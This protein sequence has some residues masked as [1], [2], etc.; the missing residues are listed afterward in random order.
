MLNASTTNCFRIQMDLSTSESSAQNPEK[1]GNVNMSQI[2]PNTVDF[3]TYCYI[4]PAVCT[5][6]IIGNITN[7]ITLA[8]PR[9][10]SVSYM[11]L[12]ALALSDLLCMIFVLCFSIAQSQERALTKSWL[13]AFYEAH[14]MLPLI[15]WALATSVLI[16]VELSLER[17]TSVV[18]PMHFRSWTS[19]QRAR[20]AI[21]VA[22]IIPALM[23]IP[24]GIGRHTIIEN[25]TDDG[26]TIFSFNDSEISTTAEWKVRFKH[27]IF[28]LYHY[29]FLVTNIKSRLW[30]LKVRYANACLPLK[31]MEIKWLR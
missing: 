14:I 8:S 23:Y 16:V 10:K 29:L 30:G 24:Y 11:Y 2:L 15:N 27:C 3:I 7:L 9:L 6:G 12:R 22:Y 25:E 31:T 13:F 28:C 5:F 26:S 4:L 17:F 19:A 18:F 21:A 1:N 20:R